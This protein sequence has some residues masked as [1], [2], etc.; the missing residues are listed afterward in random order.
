MPDNGDS[1]TTVRFVRFVL[2]WLLAVG[3]LAVYLLT[4]NHWVSPESL[5]LISNVCGLNSRVEM[6]GPL[7]LLVTM[8]F[9]WLPAAW[10]P[11]ALNLF[12]AGCAALSLAWL[13]RSVTLLPCDRTE[14]QRLRLQEGVSLFS[15][16]KAWLP[17]TLA[18][19]VC[20]LQLSFW[21]NAVVATGEM[22]D[23]L[24]FAFLVRCLL[25]FRADGNNAWLLRFALVY[26]LAVA[27]NWAM[28]AFG[29]LFFPVAV[30]AARANPFRRRVL[31]RMIKRFNDREFSRFTRFRQAMQPFNL[32]LWA[33]SLGC[34][35]AGLCLLL[36]LPL[37]ASLA[38]NA[39]INPWQALH[40]TLR[41]YKTFLLGVSKG[42]VLLLC[43]ASVLPFLFMTIQWGS[44]VGGARSADKL[45]AGMFHCLHGFFLIVCLWA[46]LDLPLSPRRLSVGF[47]CLPLYYLAALNAGYFS[48]YFL[49]VFATQPRDIRRR[50]GLLRRFARRAPAFVFWPL[51]VVVL[52]LMLC[53]SLPYILWNRTGAFG[54][55]TAQLE[56][57]IPPAGA[58]LAGE[59]SFQLLCLETTL[60]RRG[61]QNA[62]LPIDVSLLAQDPDYFA[63]KQKKHPEFHMAPPVFRMARDLTNP[64]VLVAWL[65]GFAAAREVYCL[66]PFYSYVGES[67]SLQPHGLFYQFKPCPANNL[68]NVP[69][70]P[71][72][73]AENRSFWG[74]FA[75]GPMPELI[76]RIPLPEQLAPAGSGRGPHPTAYLGPE[77]DARSATVGSW[78][79][80]ALNTWGVDLERDG[81]LSEA[82][83]A[84]ALAL[85][86]NPDNAAAQINREF[87]QDLQAHKPAVLQSIEQIERRLGKRRSWEHLLVT[88]GP[89][90]DPSVLC[91][92]G[93]I[94]ASQG[95]P[96]QAVREYARA[97]S[98]APREVDIALRLGNQLILLA[99]F[100]NA[101]DMANQALQLSPR[102][103]EGIFLKGWSLVWLKDYDRAMPLLHEALTIQTNSRA[104]LA[105]GYAHLQMGDLDAAR[106]DYEQA[107]R[108]PTNAAIAYSALF[109]IACNRKDIAAAIKYGE[110]FRSNAPPSLPEVR[111][112]AA[113]LVEL[114][115]ATVEGSKPQITDP[116]R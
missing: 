38:D 97:Q 18:V 69:L 116:S 79:S 25:E 78:Y 29:P 102:N 88:D 108:S 8:P 59:G 57:S 16:R 107:A 7:T 101:L 67:F 49:L 50:S 86:L 48:G 98:L 104:G 19:L 80:R 62:Y 84:F 89:V 15:V 73:L 109:E 21:E 22:F 91:K 14:A 93:A 82:A 70:P 71:E 42:T 46:V 103:P 66:H 40:L 47:P 27:N 51:L 34:F 28:A 113:R 43:L 100:T 114:R 24:L 5:A 20:G 68:K 96:R 61:Q 60:I 65:R 31:E 87:N 55:Y 44:P 12:A 30:W 4:L 56:K 41:T 2:P 23:L 106:Q 105:L 32:S 85:Q 76:R 74:A 17:P 36:L 58:V 33:A 92:L 72:V 112:V 94:F 64:V 115:R 11:P 110:L 53:K 111:L 9:R 54:N 83:D 90:D 77:P 10:I 13:A 35:L 95:L 63:F 37:M 3:M 26:G 99:D 81:L 1:N 75:A 52:G 45:V 39:Q 6:F